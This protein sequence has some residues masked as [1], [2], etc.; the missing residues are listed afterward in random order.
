[1]YVSF[2]LK[3]FHPLTLN[4]HAIRNNQ[5]LIHIL[6]IMIKMYCAFLPELTY[7]IMDGIK[8]MRKVMM[9]VAIPHTAQ[10]LANTSLNIFILI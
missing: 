2:F 3:L 7:V 10:I 5:T 1:M 6:E 8:M 4:G 9:K